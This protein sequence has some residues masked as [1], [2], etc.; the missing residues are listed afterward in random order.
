MANSEIYPV[1]AVCLYTCRWNNLAKTISNL[2]WK[3][4]GKRNALIFYWKMVWLFIAYWQKMYLTFRYFRNSTISGLNFLHFPCSIFISTLPSIN[5]INS[6]MA[7]RAT[8]LWCKSMN[9]HTH[10]FRRLEKSH[11]RVPKYCGI[12]IALNV[13]GHH[14]S[15]CEPRGFWR[16]LESR[17]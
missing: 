13:N 7:L 3:E 6:L 17:L 16:H 12:N 9:T 4:F 1:N 2:N 15:Y 11:L 8:D 14:F 10:N 5:S